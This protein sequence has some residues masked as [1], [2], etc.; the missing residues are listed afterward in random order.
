MLKYESSQFEAKISD[1]SI[2]I[3]ALLVRSLLGK[4]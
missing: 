4:I 2:A 3:W 1:K